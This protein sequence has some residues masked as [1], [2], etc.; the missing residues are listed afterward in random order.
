VTLGR[1]H[2]AAP[3]PRK[4]NQVEYENLG[5]VFNADGTP[6][7]LTKDML[8]GTGRDILCRCSATAF[9]SETPHTSGSP[10]CIDAPVLGEAGT[11]CPGC[12][13]VYVE[14]GAGGFASSSDFTH[15][16]LCCG[17]SDGAC[18]WAGTGLCV[19]HGRV[20][21]PSKRRHWRRMQDRVWHRTVK[22]ARG[23]GA[24]L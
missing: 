2:S 4:G 15:D 22:L 13:Y 8:S 20:R 1:G 21:V 11:V 6:T 12:Q 23:A 7:E 9:P 14:F 10:G 5:P 18:W 16:D 17:R 3:T 24:M 19:T